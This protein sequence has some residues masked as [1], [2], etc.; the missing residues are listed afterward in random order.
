MFCNCR[1]L[2]FN[3]YDHGKCRSDW[4]FCVQKLQKKKIMRHWNCFR[5]LTGRYKYARK[6]GYKGTRISDKHRCNYSLRIITQTTSCITLVSPHLFELIAYYVLCG[7]KCGGYIEGSLLRWS[8][9]MWTTDSIMPLC[10]H[11]QMKR[12]SLWLMR[13]S[14]AS[15]FLELIVY[16]SFVTI[17]LVS[18]ATRH[19]AMHELMSGLRG[20]EEGD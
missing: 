7:F 10:H 13:L 9:L 12:L 14:V 15:Y 19:R 17:R 8:A 18:E 16:Y 1:S 2:A 3:V 20:V 5:T 11:S 4:K 6:P